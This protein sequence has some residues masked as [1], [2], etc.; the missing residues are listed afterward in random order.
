MQNHCEV[1]LETIK[2]RAILHVKADI[3]WGE[4]L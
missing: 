3:M 2:N 4:V 1:D